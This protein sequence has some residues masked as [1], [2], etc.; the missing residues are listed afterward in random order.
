MKE[1]VVFACFC[2][3][4]CSCMLDFA[5][6]SQGTDA[7]DVSETI[8]EKILDDGF[9]V[10]VE[11]PEINE[12]EITDET[13]ELEMPPEVLPD[14]I[15]EGAEESEEEEEEVED[16]CSLPTVLNPLFLF[17]CLPGNTEDKTM[18]R[19]V[20]RS[21]GDLP[22]AEEPGCHTAGSN[23]LACLV[24]DFGSDANVYFDIAIG[25]GWTCGGA[26]LPKVWSYGAE[27]PV[28]VA[29]NRQVNETGLGSSTDTAGAHW[30]FQSFTT[31]SPSEIRNVEI[32]VFDKIGNPG[33]LTV[34]LRAVDG[35]GYPI[36]GDLVSAT[37]ADTAIMYRSWNIFM[38]TATSLAP[39]TQYAIVARAPSG[40]YPSHYYSWDRSSPERYP[41]GRAGESN[42][43]GSSWTLSGS[44]VDFLF[45][46]GQ[47][48]CDFH[49]AIP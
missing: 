12:M 48:G 14:E 32:F 49:F 43:S 9:E 4:S 7:D 44:D 30:L 40:S 2:L 13:A 10:V 37:K 47:V 18:W 22:W 33:D 1:I 27:L 28:T 46:T 38:F 45:R 17:F 42:D 3:F 29:E 6:K 16:P 5:G 41:D 19:W 26:G 25:S 21:S 36:G 24:E 15:A 39:S 20:D 35:N 8:G 23:R 11:I 31:G 34:S